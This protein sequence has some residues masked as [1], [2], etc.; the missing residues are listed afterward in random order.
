ML[1]KLSALQQNQNKTL[2]TVREGIQIKENRK[3][4]GDK[5]TGAKI[6]KIKSQKV[7]IMKLVKEDSWALLFCVF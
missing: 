2:E 4:N 7:L 3:T 1:T 5:E 6:N